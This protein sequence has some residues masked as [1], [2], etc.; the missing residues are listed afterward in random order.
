MKNLISW[1]RAWP[2]LVAVIGFMILA[3]LYV[4]PTLQGK[5]LNMHDDI[6]AQG[7]AREVL[8]YHKQTG[9]WSGWTNSMFAGMPAYLIAAD[10]PTSISTKLGQ[11]VN[12]ILPAPANYFLIGMVSTYV[13]LLVVGAGGWLS[14]IGGVAFA[15]SAF[16]VIN[17]EA[18][19]VSQVIAVMY[20]PGVLAGVLLA[21]RKNWLAGAAL[22][23]LFLSLELYANHVQITYYLG[24]GIVILVVLESI[25]FIRS[26]KAKA[27]VPI[28]GG[29]L[30]AAI[31][32]VGTHTTRLWNAYDYTKETIRGK[33]E[34]AADPQAQAATEGSGLGKDYAF[35][36]SYGVGELLTLIIPNAY[37]GT[38][39]GPLGN[40][41]ETYKTLT[42]RGVEPAAALS[43]LQQKPLYWGEQ[44]IMGGPNYAS[45]IVV[46]LFILGLFIIKSPVKYWAAGVVLLYIVWALGKNFASL[47]Y[48]FFDYFPMFNKFRAMTM[49]VSLVQMLMVLIGMMGL[50]ALVQKRVSW[51][52][53]QRPFLISS[54]IM[55]VITLLLALMPSVFFSFQSANDPAFTEQFAQQT[56]DKVFAQQIMSS[57][58]ED[59][60][61]L[62]KAD[63]LRSLIFVLLTAGLVWF[64]MKNKVK[65]VA[66]YTVLLLLVIF[67]L[68][69][70]DK[71]Y[72]NSDDFVGSYAAQGPTTPSPAD[73][74]IL[75]DPDP[76]YKVLD[77]STSPFQSAE[78]SYFHKSIGGYHGAKLRRYQELFERQIAKQN[79]NPGMLN[80]L[81][82]KYIIT[83]DQQ[84]NKLV[85][86]NP[87]ALGHAWFVSSYRIVPNAD[88]EMR[89]LDSLRPRE[90]A[91]LDQRFAAVLKG[92]VLK[93]DST[94]K[95]SLISYKPNE[96]VYESNASGEGLAVFSEIYYN[97]R[98]EWK[99]TI[100][101]KPAP[102]LRANYVLRA[103]RVPA[104]KHTIQFSFEPVSVTA[105]SKVDLVS[106]I[107]LLA[108]IAGAVF[109]QAKKNSPND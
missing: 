83:A 78:A 13:L 11:L 68:F 4:P 89:A 60:V 81:N 35:A 22:T 27:L 33:S 53:F 59:R 30:F 102:M 94:A 26:G 90:E 38:S 14:A 96:L 25:L 12:K 88:A 24:I 86:P 97:V 93:P 79:A 46:F 10:Y 3:I 17:L 18:G 39:Y 50:A 80:M 44:P 101:G 23:A 108:L 91:V 95:I 20:A 85:Q 87:Q 72:L 2:H 73:E 77:A 57:I 76:D 70:I 16:N 109:V 55:V 74:Q 67:D 43:F 54:G 42:T 100:D 45:V 66:F 41:S 49:V 107:L 58:V 37:G 65:P 19:H 106:S 63:A 8:N 1:Q 99:V 28:L 104:G 6:Q 103:L 34:L 32:S 5:K 15:F 82:T 62:M 31:I 71:R 36:Y 47:N 21:F 52:D 7:A 51:N 61:G 9:E 29:L 69:G 56:G 92:L 98:D 40:T 48:L 105:G 75:K 64:W 84:G